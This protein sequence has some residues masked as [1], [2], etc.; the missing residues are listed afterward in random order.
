MIY[1]GILLLNASKGRY[2]KDTAITFI[3]AARASIG[4][5]MSAKSLELKHTIK[6]IRNL[7]L[8][9]MKSKMKSKLSLTKLILQFS[10]FQV[11]TIV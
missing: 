11:S 4:S 8:R 5:N 1:V 9:L 2:V 3:E 7:V 10:V 6:L